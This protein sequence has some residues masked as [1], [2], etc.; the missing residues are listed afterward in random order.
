MVLPLDRFLPTPDVRERFDTRV[1]APPGVVMAAAS[2]FDMQ[3]IGL[4]RAVFRLREALMGGS[5]RAGPRL[6]RG[7]V[8]EAKALGWGVLAEEPERLIV[9]GAVCQ[10]WLANVRFTA[11][12]AERFA[13]YAEPN[14]VKIAWTLEAT[15]EPSGGTRFSHETRAQATDIEARRRFLRYW[16]WARVGIVGIRLL[17]LPAIRREAERVART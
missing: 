3:S 9:C 5:P 1:A 8:E 17:L 4:V 6:T 11:I 16:R 15:P 2:G 14:Q 12:P 7:F 10:P 13:T